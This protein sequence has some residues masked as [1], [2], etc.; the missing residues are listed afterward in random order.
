MEG[1]VGGVLIYTWS[2]LGVHVLMVSPRGV[3]RT[4]REREV[5]CAST[6]M[7]HTEVRYRYHERDEQAT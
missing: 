4:S 3:Y 5:G 7:S 6:T 1:G 2:T